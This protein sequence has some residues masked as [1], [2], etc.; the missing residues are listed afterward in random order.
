MKDEYNAR[1]NLH[2]FGYDSVTDDYK[3]VAISYKLAIFDHAE[4]VVWL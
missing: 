1:F 2:G 3:V 4:G